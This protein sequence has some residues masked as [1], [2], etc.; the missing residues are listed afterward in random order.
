MGY[1]EF[2]TDYF[3]WGNE[4]FGKGMG[5]VVWSLGMRNGMSFGNGVL[6]ELVGNFIYGMFCPQSSNIS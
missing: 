5:N 6:G 4:L 2:G 1:W 3:E